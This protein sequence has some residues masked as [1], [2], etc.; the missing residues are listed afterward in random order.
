MVDRE[1]NVIIVMATRNYTYQPSTLPIEQGLAGH[2]VRTGQPILVN[3]VSQDSRYVVST[4]LTKAQLSVPIKRENDVIGV[5]TLES[6]HL[7]GFGILQ[8]DTA[9]RL[10]DHALPPLRTLK[11]YE[12][13]KRANDAKSEFVSIVSHELKTPMTSMK[14]IPTCW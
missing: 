3:D 5:I 7:N 8:L 2:V 12:E 11:Q 9:T 6:P 1:Q 13:V 14:A 10:A 4:P